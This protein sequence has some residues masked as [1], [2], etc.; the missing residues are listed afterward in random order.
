MTLRSL[1]WAISCVLLQPWLTTHPWG[2][3]HNPVFV[4]LA[5]EDLSPCPPKSCGYFTFISSP[6][7]LQPSPST[8]QPSPSTLHSAPPCLVTHDP[9][10]PALLC[11]HSPALWSSWGRHMRCTWGQAEASL[12]HSGGICE[13]VEDGMLDYRQ[14]VIFV[15]LCVCCPAIF[16]VCCSMLAT[17]KPSFWGQ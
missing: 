14:T 7:T 10:P 3:L 11:V 4:L 5:L 8:L 17:N 6:S 16:P 9:W 2:S 1:S 12:G 13:S 15:P